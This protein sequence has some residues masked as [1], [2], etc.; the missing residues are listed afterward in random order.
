MESR[1]AFDGERLRRLAEERRLAGIFKRFSMIL[2]QF[3]QECR[4]VMEK[5]GKGSYN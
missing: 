4:E 2:S 3:S 1:D 5:R